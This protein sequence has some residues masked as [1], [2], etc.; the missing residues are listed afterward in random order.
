[1][2]SVLRGRHRAAARGCPKA[3]AK[4]ICLRRAVEPVLYPEVEPSRAVTELRVVKPYRKAKAES[5]SHRA[6]SSNKHR[7]A[8]HRRRVR[9]SI[10]RGRATRR[11][12][13]KWLMMFFPA[14]LRA[15]CA[16]RWAPRSQ[17][18]AQ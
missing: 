16:H 8:W 11:Y 1:M 2:K 4:V 14:L 3:D 12:R 7:S 10:V 6:G 18:A 9:P 5:R 13:P 17:I 15:Y